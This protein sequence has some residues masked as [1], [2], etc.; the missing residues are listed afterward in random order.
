MLKFVKVMK[1]YSSLKEAVVEVEWRYDKKQEEEE[2]VEIL[3]LKE[4]EVGEL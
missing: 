3:S 4:V 1:G 2:E